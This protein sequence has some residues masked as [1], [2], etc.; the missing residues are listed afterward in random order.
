MVVVAVMVVAVMVVVVAVVVAVVAAVV[1]LA[2]VAAASAE[3]LVM[4]S[5]RVA[6]VRRYHDNGALTANNN[7]STDPLVISPVIQRRST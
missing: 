5:A 1:V 6:E 7:R 3:V 2:S 4:G